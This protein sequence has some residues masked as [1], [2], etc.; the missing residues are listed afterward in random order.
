MAAS[1]LSQGLTAYRSFD[2]AGWVGFYRLLPVYAG[3]AFIIL[4]GVLLAWGASRASRLLTV[5]LGAALGYWAVPPVWYLLQLP[6]L[7]GPTAWAPVMLLALIGLATPAGLCFFALGMPVGLMAAESV[8]QPEA[9]IT[10]GAAGLV[11]GLAGLFLSRQVLALISSAVGAWLLVLGLLSA[12]HAVAPFLGEVT[13]KMPLA[14]IGVAVLL[15][16]IGAAYQLSRRSR[17]ETPQE[18]A[19]RLQAEKH[20]REKDAIERKWSP[21]GR[22][23]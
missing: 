20:Q 19:E 12:L 13:Q 15:A 1:D 22:G 6:P 17:P 11:A 14:V 16:M 23:G 2:P 7:T 8:A 10:L 18:K 4:G 3:L 21:G 5:P 9:L